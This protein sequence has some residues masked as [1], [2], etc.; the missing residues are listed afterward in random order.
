[1]TSLQT[2]GLSVYEQDLFSRVGRAGSLPELQELDF[3]TLESLTEREGVDFATALLYLR[4]RQSNEHGPWIEALEREP[5]HHCPHSPGPRVLVG[6]VPGGCH[7][8]SADSRERLRLVRDQVARA[9]LAVELIPVHSFGRL[10]EQVEI[11]CT[12]L[13]AHADHDIILVS[14]SKGGAEV[15]LALNGQ[16]QSFRHVSA[17]VD[18]SGLLFGSEWVR[19][20]LDRRISR[21]G[22]RLWC[23]YRGYPFAALDQLC[24]GR[25]SLLDFDFDVPDHLQLFHIYGF[26]LTGDLSH[27]YTERSF[28]RLSSHG[29][30]DGMGVMLGDLVR[31]PGRIYPVWRADHFLRSRRLDLRELISRVLRDLAARIEPSTQEI[32]HGD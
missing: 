29:P 14:L 8:E 7:E 27:P 11:V 6:V 32:L 21:W 28:S 19:W 16:P 4:L 24:R 20:L 25:Q 15:K 1:M 18:V 30:N 10:P 12:W 17:W 3:P 31:L 2:D 5:D 13:A 26:P 23:W 9:G 22:A